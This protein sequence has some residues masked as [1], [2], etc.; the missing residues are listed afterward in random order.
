MIAASLPL[1]RR[2]VAAAVTLISP[3]RDVPSSFRPFDLGLRAAS[4]WPHAPLGM[5]GARRPGA[6]H[7]VRSD[8][9]T[10]TEMGAWE[11]D[12][13]AAHARPLL[14]SLLTEPMGAPTRRG[15]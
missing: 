8:L 6:I 2:P 9:P 5:R 3:W 11:H 4:A 1:A 13:L 15:A 7:S 14:E 12:V 10:L